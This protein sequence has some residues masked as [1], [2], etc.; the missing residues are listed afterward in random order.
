[1]PFL[2]I[3]S[4]SGKETVR[5]GTSSEDGESPLPEKKENLAITVGARRSNG[6]E[7]GTSTSE[8]QHSSDGGDDDMEVPAKRRK[9]QNSCDGNETSGEYASKKN[10]EFKRSFDRKVYT[11]LYMNIYRAA[12][13]CM[14]WTH[15]CI[16][17]LHF[18]D[19]HCSCR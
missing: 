9:R 7:N 16:Q 12:C 3:T 13:S 10:C 2:E 1:M 17:H 8:I 14:V 11:Y 19:M 15:S 4:P 18:I 6:A 5:E